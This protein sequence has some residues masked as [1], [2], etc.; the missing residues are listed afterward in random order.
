MGGTPGVG[1]AGYGQPTG[2][3]YGEAGTGSYTGG[4]AEDWGGG[5]MF[6]TPYTAPMTPTPAPTTPTP[7]PTQEAQRFPATGAPALPFSTGMQFGGLSGAGG[8]AGDAFNPQTATGTI[9]APQ[10]NISGLPSG[11]QQPVQ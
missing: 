8:P 5:G 6:N 9:G 1:G 10:T 11:F 4:G 3:G 7:S 2:A